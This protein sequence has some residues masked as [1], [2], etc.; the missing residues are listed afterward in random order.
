MKIE[1]LHKI[2][3]NSTGICTDSRKSV[4][5][6]IFWALKG[7]KFDGNDYALQALNNG[8]SYAVVDNKSV[9]KDERYILVDNSLNKLQELA[10]FHRKTLNDI[11]I[12]AITG[13]NGKTTTKELINECLKQEY[14]VLCNPGN[15]NNHIGVPLTLLQM[16]KDHQCGIIEMGANHIGEIKNLCQIA[17]PDYGLITNIGTAHIEGFGTFEG[18][19]KAKTELY[20]HLASNNGM[21]FLNTDDQILRPQAETRNIECITYGVD[22]D[23]YCSAGMINAQPYLRVKIRDN[24]LN[25]EKEIQTKL[26][27]DYNFYNILAAGT[28]ACYF[29]VPFEKT[30]FALSNYEPEN[31]RS[32]LII[33]KRNKLFVDCYNANPTSMQLAIQNFLDYKSDQ[34]KLLILGDMLELGDTAEQ[35][36][37]K[38]VTLLKNDNIENVF[39]VGDNFK[40]GAYKSGYPVF[41]NTKELIEIIKEKEL[42]GYCILIK[43]SRSIKLEEITSYL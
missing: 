23:N 7:E 31:N 36:H 43:G 29:N 17:L 14:N 22:K 5:G 12:I 8:C 38:I 9:V 28:I 37:R 30:A 13:T 15:F 20:D 25:E 26:I 41:K 18:I 19:I 16:E 40:T 4:K 3:I 11:K 32:Q 35:E 1:A 6:N 24:K 34:M 33:T 2:F 10:T 21:I 39:L 27:G 42:T